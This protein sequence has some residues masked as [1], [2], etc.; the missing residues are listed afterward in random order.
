MVLC[1]L[2]ALPEIIFATRPTPTFG[3]WML[4]CVNILRPD[5]WGDEIGEKK[6]ESVVDHIIARR[7]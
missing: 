7:R 3:F 6:I 2:L 4:G 1:S 5:C